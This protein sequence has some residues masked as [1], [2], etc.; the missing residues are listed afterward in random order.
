MFEALSLRAPSKASTHGMNQRTNCMDDRFD[1]RELLLHLGD[2]LEAS[3]RLARES[4]PDTPVAQRVREDASLQEFSFLSTLAAKMTVAEFSAGAVNAFSQWPRELLEIELNRDALALAVQSKL[5]DGNPGGWS[6]Y[7]AHIQKKV[8][9]F[10]TGL[11]EEKASIS[12]GQAQRAA[13]KATS[14]EPMDA[15]A[16]PAEGGPSNEKRGWPWP[17]PR[18]TS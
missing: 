18:S 12:A 6:A 7:I 1:R 14:V 2:I 3:S 5:F 15:V 10:G 16:S 13:D 11:P 8:R 17:E 9:W 4:A